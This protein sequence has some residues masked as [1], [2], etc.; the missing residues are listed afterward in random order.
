L[1]NTARLI[2][3][4]N[5]GDI[6]SRIVINKRVDPAMTSTTTSK[7]LKAVIEG[8]RQVMSGNTNAPQLQ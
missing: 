8:I 7:T 3:I 1:S 5:T 4:E 6:R 2:L